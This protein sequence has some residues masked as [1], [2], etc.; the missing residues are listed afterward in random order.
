MGGTFEAFS[1]M[2]CELMDVWIWVFAL[3]GCLLLLMLGLFP[4]IDSTS[5]S[6]YISVVNIALLAGLMT[7]SMM[8]LFWCRI[9]DRRNRKRI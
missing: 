5:P 9:Q 1:E 2:V 3:T 7:S 6:Y 4:W 8:L